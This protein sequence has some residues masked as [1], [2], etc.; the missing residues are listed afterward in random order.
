MILEKE[1][2]SFYDWLTGDW[3]RA[4]LELIFFRRINDNPGAILS[5]LLSIGTLLLAALIVGFVF[6]A[7]RYGLTGVFVPFGRA[8]RR[9]VENLTNVSFARTWAIARLAIQESIRRRIMILVVLFMLIL[10]MAGWFLDRGS[11]N[12]AEL[13]MTFVM[14]STTILVLILTLF[15]SSFSLPTDFKNKTIYS[16]VTKPVRSSELVFGRILGIAIVGT[17]ML[18]FMAIASYFFVTS[19]LNHSHL[20]FERDLTP[21][22]V[23][24]GEQ[25]DNAKRLVFKGETQLNSGHR[26]LV[27]VFAD[28]TVNVGVVNGHTHRITSE[29][30]N[31]QTRYVV[32]NEQG[33]LQARVPVYGKLDF[34]SPEGLDT[35]KGINVGDEWDYRS[36]IGA[37]DEAAIYRFT[38]LQ[39]STF[40]QTD[41]NFKNGLPVEMTL[42]VFRTHKGNIE[43]RITA[44]LS[45][46]N[47]KTGLQAEVMTF[48]TEEF[49]TKYVAIPWT[50]D[51]T[52]QVVQRRGR[53]TQKTPDGR[54][55]SVFYSVPDDATASQERNDAQFSRRRTF[56]LFKDFVTDKGE[57]EIWLQCVDRQ[58]YI[59]MARS[60]LYLRAADGSVGWNFVKGFYGIWMRMLMLTAFGVLFSTFLSGPVAMISTVGVMVAGFSKAFM[61][62]IGLNKVLGG[63]PFES[64]LRIM[65]QQNMVVDLPKSFSTTFVQS[66]DNVYSMFM[67]LLGQA[68][69]PLSDY[70]VYDGAVVKGFSIPSYWLMNHT[71]MTLA[72][73][74]PL[75]IVAYLIL[76]NREVA[77]S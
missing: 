1:I 35:D 49:V 43:R 24:A 58:Q 26:H 48:S 8:I 69:P 51:G 15:L 63:G 29:K 61:I 71:I 46:R 18:L 2:P 72:Y 56:D 38:G 55:E 67:R 74:V 57:M 66:A 23:E 34:R 9:G 53:T 32:H 25:S 12:A 41:G 60:D 75:F 68:I 17:A 42:G 27:D 21:I 19:E 50:F 33:T 37:G 40:P 5:W 4:V 76:S 36:F 3:Q 64:L 14:W 16:V 7:V 62:E 77:K 47:P 10:L 54:E 31:E 39:Q 73:A 28:G 65:T 20:L 52:P 59:G 45:V 11:E 13:Y 70:S 44:S 22:S 6:C 30:V